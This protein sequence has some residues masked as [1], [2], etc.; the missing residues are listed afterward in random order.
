[1]PNFVQIGDTAVYNFSTRRP[2]AV[3]DFKKFKI[4]I[5]HALRRAK[6]RHHTKLCADWSNRFEDMAVYNLSR[7][8]PAAIL[9]FKKF[10][11]LTALALRR[12]NVHHRPKFWRPSAILDFQ[13]FKILIAYALS[14]IHI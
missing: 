11:I 6:M 12:A 2:S 7:W 4:L 10:K 9:D 3:L 14:L 8:R 5:A 1:M 13:K